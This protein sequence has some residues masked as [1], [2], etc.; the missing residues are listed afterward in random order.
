MKISVIIPTIRDSILNEKCLE[1][2]TF[3]NFETIVQRPTRVKPPGHFYQ[4]SHDYNLAIKKSKGEL[5][6]SYQDGIEIRPDT[7]ERFW[8]HYKSNPKSIV[9]AVGDQYATLI[10]P[11]KV[12]V[13]PRRRTDFGSF[14]ECVPE[15]IEFTLCSI[16][17]K[18]IF[19]VGGFDEEYD[20]GAAVGEKE[21]MR[22][23]DKAGYRSYLDQ[24]VEYRALHHERLTKDWDKYYMIASNLYHKHILEIEQGERRRVDFL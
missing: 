14:Y 24:S 13:D 22:R 6:I 4:L 17:R 18:G 20:L 2:Q 9:G 8:E 16:P 1:R 15:D 7:L 23:L 5:I 19:E 12:W 11:V 3:K 21:L 10:P